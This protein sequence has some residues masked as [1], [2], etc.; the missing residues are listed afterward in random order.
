MKTKQTILI[1]DDISE[2]VDILVEV[3]KN[4]DLVTAL[5]GKTALEIVDEEEI[6]LILLDIMMP[7]MDGFEVCSILKANEKTSHIPIIFLSAKDKAEDIQKGFELGSVDYITKPFNPTELISRVDTHLKLRAYEKNLEL[8]VQE[9]IQRNKTKQQI[10]HQQAKQAALGELL[11]HIAHQW[12]Q[13]LSSLGSINLLNIAKL[14][15]GK[16]ITKEEQL[17]STQK[18]EELISFMSETI[19]TFKNFYKPNYQN[20]DFFIHECVIDVLSIVEATFNFDNI[21]IYVH[22]DEKEKTFA[23]VNEFEQILFSILNNA[24]DIFNF[25]EIAEPIIHIEISDQKISIRDNG[26]GVDK[27]LLEKIFLPNISTTNSTGIGLYLAKEVVAKN[28]AT[29]DVKNIDNGAQFC[30]EFLTWI[31]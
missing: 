29:L 11:M 21:K 14:K 10:I 7:Y 5:D 25:R 17:D 15:N 9:E 30:I 3:L 12:K 26:G 24:R 4:H 28:N 22:S 18:T 20:S 16:T 1:V 2:N 23:N 31:D 6:D 8:R 27:D 13:P 19:N